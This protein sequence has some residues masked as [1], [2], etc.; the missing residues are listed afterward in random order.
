[1]TANRINQKII[2]YRKIKGLT[3]EQLGAMLNVSGQAV[4]KW[5]KG[6]SM[7][8]ILV[9]PE[10]CK[11]FGISVDTLLDMQYTANKENILKDAALF[12]KDYGREKALHE[13]ISM[14][15]SES[16][17][18]AANKIKG[19]AVDFSNK[20]MR[21]YDDRGM[22]FVIANKEYMQQCFSYDPK[23]ISAIL[24]FLADEHS[25]SILP[26]INPEK[27]VTKEDLE[28]LTGYDSAKINEILLG[29]TERNY[30]CK[31]YDNSGKYGYMAAEKMFVLYMIFSGLMFLRKDGNIGNMWFSRN[32]NT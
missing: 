32:R 25:L 2:D 7:P 16:F 5:E 3:Q 23:D 12:A 26:H 18:D 19:N 17:K 1:M 29:M 14:T 9:L 31:E 30:I 15:F 21:V 27:A 13:F 8:D 6:E 10:L 24:T 11:I 28:K 22:G 4:S 20:S